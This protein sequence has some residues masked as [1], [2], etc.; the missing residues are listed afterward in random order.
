MK[1]AIGVV[2]FVF[3]VSIFVLY[4]GPVDIREYYVP[5]AKIRICESLINPAD[6]LDRMKLACLSD[7]CFFFGAYLRL[8]QI[9]EKTKLSDP[10]LYSQTKEFIEGDLYCAMYKGHHLGMDILLCCELTQPQKDV[11]L[12]FYSQ[13]PNCRK[14]AEL[15]ASMRREER[16]ALAPD[17]YNFL[18]K[19]NLEEIE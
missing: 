16:E 18:R 14:T 17:F 7:R 12:E 11:I 3:A 19:Q 6:N 1:Y 2:F 8:K 9:N 13:Y 10:K 4:C 5:L 15:L